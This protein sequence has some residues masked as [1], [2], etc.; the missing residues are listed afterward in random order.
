MLKSPLLAFFIVHFISEI[1]EQ[2]SKQHNTENYSQSVKNE[3][4]NTGNYS[5]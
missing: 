2:Q 1:T 4:N 3:T 5:L